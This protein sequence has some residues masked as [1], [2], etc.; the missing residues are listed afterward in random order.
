MEIITIKKARKRIILILFLSILCL[1]FISFLP[2]I[3]VAEN[4]RISEDLHFNYEMM[5]KSD[6]TQINYL[7][8]SLM[9]INIL[10]WTI[11][12][13]SLISFLIL[14]YF[15]SIKRTNFCQV[16]ILTASIIIFILCIVVIFFQII[17]SRTISD[18]DYITASMLFSPFAYA[19]I[20]F[21]LSIFLLVISG[22]Y[23]INLLK[24]TIGV[25]QIQ[26]KEKK[27]KLEK[28]LNKSVGDGV[29]ASIKDIEKVKTHID[30]E[31]KTKLAE[32]EKLLDK[33]E[34]QRDKQVIDI[35]PSDE[36]IEKIVEK[37]ESL[38]KEPIKEEENIIED[39]DKKSEVKSKESEN[40]IK[41]FP[42][43]EKKE[44]IDDDEEI[45]QSE[46]FE[47][48]LSSAIKKKQS[49]M[50]TKKSND[51]K[52]TKEEK[53]ETAKN[54]EKQ[55]INFKTDKIYLEKKG[56]SINKIIN[57]KCPDCNQI[58]PSEKIDE[59]QKITCPN[60][61]KQGNVKKKI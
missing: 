33:K 49:E 24:E 44:E 47:N 61:G 7:A 55:D 45:H 43:V 32:I 58:F 35:N 31:R 1:I 16:L 18:I 3:S 48:V 27:K 59:K 10:F 2:W 34:I 54:I 37:E 23:T 4:D 20:Q 36:D 9:D 53:K 15:I 39:Q 29:E 8:N 30:P 6:N 50:K 13:I 14:I 5:R 26:Q 46:Y 57:I 38:E 25:I 40:Q 21:I 60:C 28:I 22:S 52:K 41:P 51:N 56:D 42:T 17:F 12:V 19:Y 11:I